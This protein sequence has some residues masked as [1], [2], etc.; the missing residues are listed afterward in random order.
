MSECMQLRNVGGFK[1]FHFRVIAFWF[2][3]TSLLSAGIAS[4]LSFSLICKPSKCRGN[5]TWDIFQ[6]SLPNVHIL[7]I[8]LHHVPML[9]FTLWGL[10]SNHCLRLMTS[11]PLSVFKWGIGNQNDVHS[12]VLRNLLD[13]GC[14]IVVKHPQRCRKKLVPVM[15]YTSLVHIKNTPK[16]LNCLLM[17]TN[18]VC[19]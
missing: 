19:A 3:C 5:I 6:T 14:S 11:A 9:D 16:T 2:H 17:H 12:E 7:K 18:K 13:E 15:Y 4:E 10:G 8:V 1:L